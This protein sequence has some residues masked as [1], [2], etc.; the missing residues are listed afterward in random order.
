MPKMNVSSLPISGLFGVAK[1]SGPTSMSIVNDLQQ[2]IVRSRLFV[3]VE[4]LEKIKDKKIDRRRGKLGR[5]AVKV[6]QGGTL[7]PLADG[8]LG[9]THY[10][11]F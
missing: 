8:V 5:E 10:L 6:G 9:T 7:D 4:K 1:P 2:L 11:S 3:S